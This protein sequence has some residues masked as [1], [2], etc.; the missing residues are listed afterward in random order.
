MLNMKRFAILLL[1]CVQGTLPSEAREKLTI[2]EGS[3]K[4]FEWCER[5]NRTIASQGKCF[6]RCTVYWSK[7]GSDAGSV[8]K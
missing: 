6:Q 1:F 8:Q 4:C 5:H 2:K 3:K 7:N